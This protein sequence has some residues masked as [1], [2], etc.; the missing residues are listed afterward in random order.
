MKFGFNQPSDL[1]GDLT[2]LCITLRDFGKRLNKR[3]ILT[4]GTHI[5]SCTCTSIVDCISN[6]MP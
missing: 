1:G 3:R 4:S 5:T 6:I 2:E